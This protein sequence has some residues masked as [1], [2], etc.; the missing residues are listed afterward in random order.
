LETSPKH[1]IDIEGRSPDLRTTAA[2]LLDDGIRQPR[3]NPEWRQRLSAFE[4]NDASRQCCSRRSRHFIL[5]C[6]YSRRTIFSYPG[7]HQQFSASS[8][9]GCPCGT[10]GCGLALSGSRPWHPAGARLPCVSFRHGAVPA[11][12]GGRVSAKDE[13][14]ASFYFHFGFVHLPGQS[15]LILLPLN[16]F[17]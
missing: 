6:A 12:V 2:A 3:L 15:T 7:S 9:I 16:T 13:H 17:R 5:T 4:L 10:T 14:V 1:S 8:G 11:V